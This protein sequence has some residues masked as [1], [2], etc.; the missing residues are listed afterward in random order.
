MGMRCVA[1]CVCEIE[2]R[3]YICI[4]YIVTK[5]SKISMLLITTTTTTTTWCWHT[6]AVVL[7]AV[8]VVIE[9]FP[10][11]ESS[12]G[13]LALNHDFDLQMT[14]AGKKSCGH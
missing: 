13:L 3:R 2:E 14:F 11:A 7:V 1:W 5:N 9:S 6:T 12:A 8:V 4:G 10:E